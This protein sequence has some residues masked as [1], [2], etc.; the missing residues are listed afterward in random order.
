MSSTITT[1]GTI[2][3]LAVD[4]KQLLE[5]HTKLASDIIVEDNQEQRQLTVTISKDTKQLDIYHATH[6]GILYIYLFQ[7]T[8]KTAA[9]STAAL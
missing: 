4:I 8:K 2:C 1:T 5:K 3:N 9:A 7:I 6:D